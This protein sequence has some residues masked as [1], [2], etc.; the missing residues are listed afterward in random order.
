MCVSL[1]FSDESVPFEDCANIPWRVM[2]S[3]SLFRGRR[4]ET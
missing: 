2:G 4:Q 3:D 1:C